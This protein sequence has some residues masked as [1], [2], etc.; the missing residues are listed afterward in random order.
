MSCRSGNPAAAA[1][2][3]AADE[4]RRP[5][6]PEVLQR[7]RREA[8]RVTLVAHEHDAATEVA[9]Q[10]R[11]AMARGRVA[12]PFEDVAGVEDRAGDQPVACPLHLGADVDEDRAIPDGVE[13]VVDRHPVEPPSRAGQHLLDRHP[14]HDASPI[15]PTCL[16]GARTFHA[17]RRRERPAVPRRGTT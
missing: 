15:T 17:R 3:E 1:R 11:I 14:R 9:A 13:G 2:L 12:A 8:R 16:S 6:E 10:P 4:V 5:R 7:R